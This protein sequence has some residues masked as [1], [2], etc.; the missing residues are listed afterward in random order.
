MNKNINEKEFRKTLEK[1]AKDLEE[2]EEIELN[3]IKG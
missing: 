1:M 2:I 3:N